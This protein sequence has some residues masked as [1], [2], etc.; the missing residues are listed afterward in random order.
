MQ[1]TLV[2]WIVLNITAFMYGFNKTGIVGSGVICTP[3]MLLYFTAGQTMGILLP[4]LVVADI[5][6]VIIMRHSVRWLHILKAM[7]WALT[8][9][10]AGWLIARHAVSDAGGGDALLRK[11]IAGSL[12]CLMLFGFYLRFNPSLVRG[13]PA[14]AGSDRPAKTWFACFMGVMGGITTMLANNGGPAWVVYLMTLGLSVKEFIGT[15]AWLFFI[16]N[17]TKIPF[18]ISLG[19]INRDAIS[20]IPYLLPALGIGLAV[21][22]ITV[23]RLSKSFFDNVTQF[24]AL[25]G[26]LYLLFT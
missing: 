4:L 20:L 17:V 2:Q 11:I 22:V 7:P 13:Q 10:V 14:S 12:V 26:S 1:P 25:A 8:G 24:L 19:F 15:A 16:Q 18:G 6:T 23:K 3:L 9:I 21:G 5:V